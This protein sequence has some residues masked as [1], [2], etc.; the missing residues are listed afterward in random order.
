MKMLLALNNG[1]QRAKERVLC[2]PQQ[3]RV[4]ER[5]NHLRETHFMHILLSIIHDFT[6]HSC[7]IVVNLFF[8][9]FN[10]RGKYY[11]RENGNFPRKCTRIVSSLCSRTHKHNINPPDKL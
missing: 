10:S 8:S 4:K 7:I 2:Q 1:C 9:D 6:Q 5:E 11:E 3:Q